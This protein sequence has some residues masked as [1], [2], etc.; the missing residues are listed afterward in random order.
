MSSVLSASPGN[1]GLLFPSFLLDFMTELLLRM[2]VSEV[3]RQ[4]EIETVRTAKERLSAWPPAEGALVCDMSFNRLGPCDV[5]EGSVICRP[6]LYD[7][8]DER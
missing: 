4:Q 3:C 6:Q 8:S 5:R 7:K 2:A 1:T